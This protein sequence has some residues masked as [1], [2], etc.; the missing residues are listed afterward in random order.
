MGGGEKRGRI[1]RELKSVAR[2]AD[3]K[4]TNHKQA[5]RLDPTTNK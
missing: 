4:N 5:Q 2:G 1:M 3:Y